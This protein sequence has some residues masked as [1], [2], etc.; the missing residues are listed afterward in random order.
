MVDDHFDKIII[1]EGP[2]DKSKIEKMITDHV[3]II[4]TYGTFSIE[5]FDTLLETYDLDNREVYILVDEDKAGIQ[6]RKQ[7][8]HELPNAR[9]LYVSEEYGEVAA[10]PEEILAQALVSNHIN[11]HP[12]YLLQ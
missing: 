4:C 9:H 8:R 2:T 10:T 1:V 12:I 7:L 5:R 11:V 6:L 3:K